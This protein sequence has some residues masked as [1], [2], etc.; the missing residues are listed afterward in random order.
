MA[1]DQVDQGVEDAV[2]RSEDGVRGWELPAGSGETQGRAGAG[3]QPW[4]VRSLHLRPICQLVAGGSRKSL[5]GKQL[6]E[7]FRN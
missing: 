5:N 1:L 3:D 6:F 7:S 2:V 4:K